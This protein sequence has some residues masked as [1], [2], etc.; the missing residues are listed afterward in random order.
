MDQTIA[1]TAE[2]IR[3]SEVEWEMFVDPHERP[4]SP[5]RMLK[6]DAPSLLE[7]D[8]PP[9]FYAGLH[10]HP[11]DTLYFVVEGEMLIGPEGSFLPGDVRWVKAG[12]PYGPEEAG[13][14]GVRFFL[15]SMGNEVGLN[16]AD[17]YDVPE[18]LTDRLERLP[19]VI[20]RVNIFD[21]PSAELADGSKIQT[22]C[23]TEPYIHRVT[24][25][26]GAALPA[27]KHGVDALYMVRSGSMD[28]A[29]IGSFKDEDFRWV[30]AG[31]TTNEL[32]AGPN[33]VDLIIIGVGGNAAFEWTS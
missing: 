14:D 30:S 10:W 26:P 3:P 4:T 13:P 15:I 31:Q 6:T 11:F 1:Q 18:P 23:D 7:V 9:N 32:T 24:L 12:H 20:G 27:Y 33:G 29:G 16:W 21:L 5:V 19:D 25:E 28:V 17:I 22:I 2:R 8:F